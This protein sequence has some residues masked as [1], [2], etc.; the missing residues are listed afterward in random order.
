[1]T[2]QHTPKIYIQDFLEIPKKVTRILKEAY[3]LL[4]VMKELSLHLF[5]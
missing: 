3:I 2:I 4:H 1:M 5:G